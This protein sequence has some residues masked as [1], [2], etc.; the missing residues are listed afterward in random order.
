MQTYTVNDGL[1]ANGVNSILQ[2]S[3]GFLWIGTAE[4]LSMYDGARV[5]SYRTNE[6]LPLNF[7]SALAES[8]TS[9][10]TMWVGTAGGGLCRITDGAVDNH[11]IPRT[12][13]TSIVEDSTGTVWVGTES[14]VYTIQDDSAAEFVDAS[15]Q[16]F[17]GGIIQLIASSLWLGWEHDI[18][19]ISID[20]GSVDTLSHLLKGSGEVQSVAA[21]GQELLIG[22]STGY[23]LILR[24][25]EQ[26]TK[27]RIARSPISEIFLDQSGIMYLGTYEGLY[28]LRHDSTTTQL[29]HY[30]EANG[31]PHNSVISGIVDREGNVWLG[32]T[33]GLLKWADRSLLRFPLEPLPPGHYTNPLGVTD[34]RGHHWVVTNSGLLELSVNTHGVWQTYIHRFR[35]SNEQ[36]LPIS[37]HVHDNNQLWIGFD[38]HGIHRYN[39]TPAET[40]PS[41]LSLRDALLF[42]RDVPTIYAGCFF[43]D[44]DDGM[45]ASLAEG[46]R[47]VVRLSLN[48]G[49]IRSFTAEDG[50]SSI[51][52]RAIMQD[53]RGNIWLGGYE[54]GISVSIPGDEF[55]FQRLT[56][57]DGLLDDKI[58]SLLEDREGNIWVGTRDGGLAKYAGGKFTTVSVSNGLLS[59]TVWSLSEDTKGNIWAGTAAGIQAIRKSDLKPFPVSKEFRVG[60]VHG[61]GIFNDERLWFATA[62]DVF[63]HDLTSAVRNTVPPLVHITDVQV[64]GETIARTAGVEL[65]FD[66]N[67]VTV[68]Y[69]GVSFRDESLTRYQ[70]RLRGLVA[71]WS[72]ASD[73]RAVTFA[74]L[75]PGSYVFEVRAINND[76]IH[77]LSTA[78]FPFAI[79]APWWQQWWF[80][81]L[82]LSASVLL[83]YAL[84]R[85]RVGKLLEVERTRQRIARDLH[86]EIGGT[87]SSISHFV[88]AI[89]REKKSNGAR[90][91]K[92]LDLIAQ[93]SQEVQE[94]MSDII[95]AIEP[96][97]DTWES[98]FAK[99]RRYASDLCESKKMQ[100]HIDIPQH[101]VDKRMNLEW[102]KNLWLIYKEMVTNAVKHSRAHKLSVRFEVVHDNV[103]L[104]VNDDGRGF[105]P[106]LPTSRHGIKNIQARANALGASVQLNTSAG[107]GTRWQLTSPF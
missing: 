50:V 29:V 91:S 76:G 73:Q 41:R 33:K 30:T 94:A 88:Q 10:G 64:N 83:L 69:I 71:D 77:S 6:G 38:R 15:G 8:K 27:R 40:F 90:T 105:N 28:I 46:A 92:M 52:V 97:N 79:S 43:I 21:R 81:G 96:S 13:V 12:Y 37:V 103:I 98:F 60:P 63:I 19:R 18:F 102:R 104:E 32:T 47:R 68:E 36:L 4:G 26:V 70:Y 86:D 87:L 56:T 45:W 14:A 107:H 89:G 82:V 65:P 48:D 42:K 25:T 16:T 61:C 1:L 53:S 17:G 95:W 78:G 84:Y 51:D 3:R 80:Y 31:L 44:R 2:D 72:P 35:Y 59:N 9:P 99:C 20:D 58:R 7:I 24:G 66:R 55:K 106:E 54:G 67:T 34:S 22:T 101:S 75:Q 11:W 62:E 23:L 100:Y 5:V 39:I 85:Y 57:A 74:Q 93:G 49:S